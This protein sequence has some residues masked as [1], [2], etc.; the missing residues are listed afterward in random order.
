LRIVL[1]L[2]LASTCREGTG[3]SREGMEVKVEVEDQEFGR[4]REEIE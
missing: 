4:I 2:D 3:K 1:D